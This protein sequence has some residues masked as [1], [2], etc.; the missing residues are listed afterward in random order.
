M[1]D[2][3]V[4]YKEPGTDYLV[5]RQEKNMII[6]D[7]TIANTPKAYFIGHKPNPLD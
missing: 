5:Q 7:L 6:Q 1:V 2:I 4:R 3:S